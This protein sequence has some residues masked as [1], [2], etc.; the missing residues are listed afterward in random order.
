MHAA[1]IEDFEALQREFYEFREAVVDLLEVCL[2]T[3]DKADLA[4]AVRLCHESIK[5]RPF[6]PD[7]ELEWEIGPD[8]EVTF[9]PADLTFEPPEGRL[10]EEDDAA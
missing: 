3:Q 7:F 2:L 8:R 10:F 4:A 1:P 6:R 5:P 9:D